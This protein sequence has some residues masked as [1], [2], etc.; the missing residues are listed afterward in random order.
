MPFFPANTGL[1][2][3]AQPL[4]SARVEVNPPFLACFFCKAAF[5]QRLRVC[6][7]EHEHPEGQGNENTHA[8]PTRELQDILSISE[9]SLTGVRDRGLM[10]IIL[11]IAE[12]VGRAGEMAQYSRTLAA[13]SENPVRFNS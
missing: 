13:L 9:S 5:G 6:K 4:P 3:Q 10:W 2:V 1:T 12:A 11:P 7:W 8:S